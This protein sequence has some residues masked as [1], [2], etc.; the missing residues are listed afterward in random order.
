MGSI[1]NNC[2][3]SV[4][5]ALSILSKSQ[6]L[7]K[8]S[9]PMVMSSPSSMKNCSIIPTWHGFLPFFEISTLIKPPSQSSMLPH[10]EPDSTFPSGSS[11]KPVSGSEFGV[12][13]H[14]RFCHNSLL[15]DPLTY[16]VVIWL[17]NTEHQ[18]IKNHSSQKWHP[19]LFFMTIAILFFYCTNLPNST[20][21]PKGE[22]M[23]T[24][25]VWQLF[26]TEL[27]NLSL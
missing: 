13:T 14:S 5:S 11:T 27:P 20:H 23:L 3:S 6:T 22:K 25:Y 16:H 18:N 15:C 4:V 12:S 8:P 21:E 10:S 1:S 17:W 9:A 26:G 7:T 2:P 19:A 24:F